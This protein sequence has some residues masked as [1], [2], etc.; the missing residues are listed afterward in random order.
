[1]TMKEQIAREMKEIEECKRGV[2]EKKDEDGTCSD[3]K[4]STRKDNILDRGINREKSNTCSDGNN[5]I[6]K[7]NILDRLMNRERKNVK[8]TSTPNK[9]VS[10]NSTQEPSSIQS[11]L[12]QSIFNG[13]AA[14]CTKLVY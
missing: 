10:S 3:G 5:P 2:S 14:M 9:R 11:V 7:N 1:M 6:R 4:N 12:Q 13:I 8:F